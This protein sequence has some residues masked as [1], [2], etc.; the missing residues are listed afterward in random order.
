MFWSDCLLIL[1]VS[2]IYI[3]SCSST[4]FCCL[5]A[6]PRQINYTS[7]C[8]RSNCLLVLGHPGHLRNQEEWPVI[9]HLKCKFVI[10]FRPLCLFQ[11]IALKTYLCVFRSVHSLVSLP[12]KLIRQDGSGANLSQNLLISCLCSC[13]F[14]PDLCCSKAIFDWIIDKAPYWNCWLNMW[15]DG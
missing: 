3:P 2:T 4:T 1:Y 9:F 6:P 7:E 12:R 11:R 13:L 14:A 15:N 10:V 8:R 5:L